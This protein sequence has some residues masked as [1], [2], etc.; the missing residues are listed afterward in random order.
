[1]IDIDAHLTLW[2]WAVSIVV[3]SEW[4]AMLSCRRWQTR[5]CAIESNTSHRR[6]DVTVR[7]KTNLS[8]GLGLFPPK[9][10]LESKYIFYN[11]MNISFKFIVEIRLTS[12]TRHELSE[13]GHSSRWAALAICTC[14]WSDGIIHVKRERKSIIEVRALKQ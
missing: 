7:L 8:L 5:N 14:V 13:V 3:Q 11:R 9:L 4:R 1:M 12:L 6:R 10:Q 2:L